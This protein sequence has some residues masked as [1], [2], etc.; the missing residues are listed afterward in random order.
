MSKWLLQSIHSLTSPVDLVKRLWILGKELG[1]AV[2]GFHSEQD[3]GCWPFPSNEQSKQGRGS[4][5]RQSSE[6]TGLKSVC[7]RGCHSSSFHR[8]GLS[9]A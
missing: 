6:A 7:T 9:C 8:R 3:L 4:E 1:K 5:H 2:V